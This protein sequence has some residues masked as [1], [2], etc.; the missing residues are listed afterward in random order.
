MHLHMASAGYRYV[1]PLSHFCYTPV[2]YAAQGL[3][4][5][6]FA[7]RWRP[8]SALTRLDA[9]APAQRPRELLGGLQFADDQVFERMARLSGGAGARLDEDLSTTKRPGWQWGQSWKQSTKPRRTAFD[10]SKL[11]RAQAVSS[12]IGRM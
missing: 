4:T 8:A 12:L 6:G 2:L 10:G 1:R 5:S 11:R 7:L 3:S 9:R